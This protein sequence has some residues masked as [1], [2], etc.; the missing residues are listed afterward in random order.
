MRRLPARHPASTDGCE[1]PSS[2]SFFHARARARRPSLT[3]ALRRKLIVAQGKIPSRQAPV[4]RVNPSRVTAW[5][6]LLPPPSV[7]A[8]FLHVSRRAPLQQAQRKP[9]VGI[10]FS[11]VSG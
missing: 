3:T 5:I 4:F 2:K 9:R 11:Q 10:A 8:H 7:G 6:P 1:L